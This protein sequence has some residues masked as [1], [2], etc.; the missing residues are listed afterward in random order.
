ML[1]LTIDDDGIPFDPTQTSVTDLSVPADQRPPGGMGIILLHQM[2]DGLAY[3]RVNGHN[4][5]TIK[6]KRT[7]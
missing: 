4:I 7:L 2:T 5:L 6:K 1:L 3:Q